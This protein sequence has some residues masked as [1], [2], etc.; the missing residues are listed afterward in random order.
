VC[1]DE[2][3]FTVE[4]LAFARASSRRLKFYEQFL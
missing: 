2:V 4:D 3:I 1:R